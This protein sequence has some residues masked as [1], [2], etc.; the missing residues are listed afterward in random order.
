MALQL[1]KAKRIQA[2]LKIAIGGPSGSG[3]TLS[4]L[5]MAYGLV[6]AEHPAWTDDEV[7]GHIVVLDTE[8]SS[9]SLYVGK[10]V[11][12]TVVGSYNVIDIT[13][14][15]EEQ[16]LIDALSMSEQ[17]NMECAIIDSASAFWMDA[18]E[19]QGKIAERTKSN[20]SAWKPVKND[21]QKMMQAIL[22]CRMH[23]IANY[24]AKIEYTQ[25]VENGKKV[26]RSLGMGIIAEG[27][28]SYEYTTMLMLDDKHEANATKD[29]TGLFD[30]Q[31]FVVTADTG[32]KLYQWMAEGEVPPPPPPEMHKAEA[33]T[34]APAAPDE[35]VAKAM[36]LID[37]LAKKLAST[38]EGKVAVGAVVEA[39]VGT[40]NYKTVTDI[41]QLRALYKA[42]QNMEKENN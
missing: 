28:T 7:W 31:Y 32:R 42:L 3:K 22:Q 30:G 24:R 8:N 18:L 26:V 27:N 25:D 36:G 19:T 29:R 17:A 13:P 12:P 34:P 41:D 37:A 23:V 40:K 1:T 6:K 38:P 20:F 10:R 21:Q 2:K 14:P 4:S 35:Q 16:T 39:T 15:F 5:L 11:G 33:P 9:A